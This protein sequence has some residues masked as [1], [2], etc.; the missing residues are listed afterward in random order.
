MGLRVPPLEIGAII[1]GSV[2]VV[3]MVA[4]MDRPVSIVPVPMIGSRAIPFHP[5]VF[6]PVNVFAGPVLQSMNAP[7]FVRFEPTISPGLP[8]GLLDSPLLFV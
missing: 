2:T 7:S 4:V 1:G 8:Y 6:M 3:E 5:I